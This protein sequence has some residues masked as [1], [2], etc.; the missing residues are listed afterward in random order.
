MW[1]QL[2][3][4][5]QAA[6]LGCSRKWKENR[7]CSVTT[8]ALLQGL[9]ASRARGDEGE[10]RP[11]KNSDWGSRKQ[12]PWGEFQKGRREMR[13]RVTVGIRGRIQI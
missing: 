13:L 7:P 8:E 5:V 4:G 12:E 10:I 2:I 3:P 9:V 1:V 6:V 11:I